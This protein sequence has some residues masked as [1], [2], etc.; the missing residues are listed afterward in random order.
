MRIEHVLSVR[1]PFAHL[2]V[3]GIKTIENRSVPFPKKFQLPMWVAIHS[4]LSTDWLQ[5]AEMWADLN[6][7]D[8]V[9]K[10]WIDEPETPQTDT[11]R[12]WSRSEIIGAVEILGSIPYGDTEFAAD[13]AEVFAGFP[14]AE[15]EEEI[16]RSD[17]ASGDH[18]WIIGRAI[19]FR[20]PIVTLGALGVRSMP[21]ALVDLVAKASETL[22]DDPV[23]PY[24]KSVIYQL[25]KLKAKE[26]EIYR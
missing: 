23:A 9:R 13:Q 12:N 3:S 8:A 5:D 21:P 6:E 15:N 19:R 1:E 18:C 20:H 17:W 7:F 26:L 16:P 10:S 2:L 4:S 24:G 22:L 25:P 14:P 11:D